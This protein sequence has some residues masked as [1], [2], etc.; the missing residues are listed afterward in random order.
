MTLKKS[1]PRRVEARRA[2]GPKAGSPTEALWAILWNP[3]GPTRPGREGSQGE[4][5]RNLWWRKKED[6]RNF[7]VLWSS[8][9]EGQSGEKMFK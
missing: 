6:E 1:G 7:G 9:A 2:G 5:T 8:P 3:G 4:K